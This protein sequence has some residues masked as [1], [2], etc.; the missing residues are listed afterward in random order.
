M[1]FRLAVEALGAGTME[2][3]RCYETS[4]E[5]LE[6]KTNESELSMLL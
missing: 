2:G 4:I 1:T 6:D 3:V 5:V